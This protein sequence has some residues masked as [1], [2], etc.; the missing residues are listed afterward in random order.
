[1]EWLNLLYAFF[2]AN[3]L[4]YGGGP[5]TIPLLYK[6]IVPHYNWMNDLGFSNMLAL[7]NT[8]PGPIAT[9]IAA[10]IGYEVGG[11]IGILIAL[12]VTIVPSAIALI[13]LL[14][15]LRKHRTSPIVKGMTLLVQPVITI[16]MAVLTWQMASNSIQ[17]VGIWQSLI[18]AAVAFWAMQ[19]RRIH[20]AIVIAAAFVYGAFALPLFT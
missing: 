3:L 4:G 18:I 2:I 15:L 1:M 6:E 7:G 17:S 13:L 9:K 14:K 16:M 20:P 10:Y 8:L 12:L 19:Q 5:A 11:V